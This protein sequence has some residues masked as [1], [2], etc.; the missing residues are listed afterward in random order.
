M[1]HLS[2]G[3]RSLPNHPNN[4]KRDADHWGH[5][6]EPSD[7]IAPV[8]VGVHIVVLQRF[9]FNQEEQ[10]NTLGKTMN[11]SNLKTFSVRLFLKWS[12]TDTYPL[13]MQL[14]IFVIYQKDFCWWF[15]P[16]TPYYSFKW[17]TLCLHDPASTIVDFEESVEEKTYSTDAWGQD[18]PAPFDEED[19][20]VANHV[21]DV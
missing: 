2:E 20:F 15:G 4:P 1:S 11:A 14:R 6:H 19:R 21:F 10:E 8:W 9:V 5:G 17:C 18:H 7:T 3:T 13:K 12:I 16:L